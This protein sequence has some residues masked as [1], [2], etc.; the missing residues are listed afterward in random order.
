MKNAQLGQVNGLI[1]LV[2]GFHSVRLIGMEPGNAARP[3]KTKT[4][5]LNH[6]RPEGRRTAVNCTRPGPLYRVLHIFWPGKQ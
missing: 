5:Q 2:R 1:G 3:T 4:D 6:Q